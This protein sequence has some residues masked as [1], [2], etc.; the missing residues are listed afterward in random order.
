MK[1]VLIT[2]MPEESRAVIR[3]VKSFQEL[4]PGNRKSYC[5]RLAAHEVTLL[6]AG[7]G[8]LNAG[9]A[10][11]ALA[12]EK[13]D[14]MISTGFGGAVLAGLRVGDAVMAERVLQWNG[15]GFENVSVGFYG[16]NALAETLAIHRGSFIT[17]DVILNKRSTA[18]ILPP[19]TANPVLEMESSAVAR[20][21]AA[22]GIP[23]LAMRVI[24]DPWYE[25]F[26]FDIN[27]FCDDSMRIRPAKVFNVIVRR[28]R[29]IPQLIRLALNSRIASFSLARVMKRLFLQI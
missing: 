24:S 9:W 7:M 29:I 11:S 4:L 27:E 2:A 12:A 5:I 15:S 6:E 18:R 17:S 10:A 20:V 14:L 21:A 26:G 19:G 13:P 23:F 25:E 1:I 28:P 22:H 3:R 16:R 8:L